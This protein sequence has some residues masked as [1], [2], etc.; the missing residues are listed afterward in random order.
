MHAMHNDP[1]TAEMLLRAAAEADKERLL[2]LFDEIDLNGDGVL[3]KWE[4][5][6][7]IK[8]DPQHAK[9]LDEKVL[10]RMEEEGE[11]ALQRDRFVRWMTL[12]K[13][14]DPLVSVMRVGCLTEMPNKDEQ[15][16]QV[17]KHNEI[18]RLLMQAE[19]ASKIEEDGAVLLGAPGQRVV[20]KS[21]PRPP[22]APRRD[23]NTAPSRYDKPTSRSTSR[24]GGRP[25][26]P[27]LCLHGRETEGWTDGAY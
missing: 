6:E 8:R 27:V 5:T 3:A 2:E 21:S 13:V 20:Q 26:T 9:E 23:R 25:H 16:P 22:S 7:A 12:H 19:E 4:V 15:E 14:N 1:N 10:E 18:M 24:T 17:L 11:G